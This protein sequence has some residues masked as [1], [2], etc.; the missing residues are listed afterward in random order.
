MRSLAS[1]LEFATSFAQ[2]TAD[3]T[4]CRWPIC[5]AASHDAAQIGAHAPGRGRVLSA[6]RSRSGSPCDWPC[7]PMTAKKAATFEEDGLVTR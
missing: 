1:L 3:A 2:T 4:G 6:L 5:R 7:D